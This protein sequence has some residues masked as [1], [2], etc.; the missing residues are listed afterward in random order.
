MGL[1]LVGKA[2]VFGGADG[3]RQVRPRAHRHWP[4]HPAHHGFARRPVTTTA[5]W[6]SCAPATSTCAPASSSVT[7]VAPPPLRRTV[8]RLALVDQSAARRPHGGRGLGRDGGTGTHGTGRRRAG[9]RRHGAAGDHDGTDVLQ[10]RSGPNR[11]R[12]RGLSVPGS[13]HQR[14]RLEPTKNG[15]PSAAETRPAPDRHRR[16]RRLRG[17]EVVIHRQRADLRGSPSRCAVRAGP[18][19][20]SRLVTGPARSPRPGFLLP[21][22]D[23]SPGVHPW[24][25]CRIPRTG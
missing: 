7:P 2:V 24:R 15:A 3:G 19:G 22:A 17:A 6:T 14:L 18:H 23:A 8:R 4:Q 21:R 13:P 10:T 20:P 9:R 1:P 11:L 12:I 5:G 16:D 25:E